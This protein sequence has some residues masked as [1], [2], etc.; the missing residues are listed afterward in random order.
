MTVDPYTACGVA[1]AGCFIFS[2]F[3]TL[4]GWLPPEDWRFPALNLAGAGL[5]LVSL[6]AGWNLASF[7]LES[8][9]SGISLWGLARSLRRRALQS[10]IR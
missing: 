6:I 8:F 3:A 5:H 7:I 10:S 4:R 1:G 9:W 2:Y